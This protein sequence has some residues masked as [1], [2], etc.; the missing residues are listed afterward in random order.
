MAVSKQTNKKTFSI[1]IIR[2]WRHITDFVCAF[3][4]PFFLFIDP[5]TK[6]ETEAPSLHSF[7]NFV[8]SWLISCNS[9]FSRCERTINAN[10]FTFTIKWMASYLHNWQLW[11]LNLCL[12]LLS[13]NGRFFTHPIC[14]KTFPSNVFPSVEIP[15]FFLF[16]LR[17]ELEYLI[18]ENQKKSCGNVLFIL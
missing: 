8:P 5:K 17:H 12:L 15:F 13:L 1:L 2:F 7:S 6:Q 3:F 11:G 9:L 4:A 10:A 14:C 16:I 18:F